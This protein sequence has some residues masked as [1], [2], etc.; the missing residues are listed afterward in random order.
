V[1][2][3]CKGR[4][5]GHPIPANIRRI[6]YFDRDTISIIQPSSSSCAWAF[7]RS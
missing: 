5:P 6:A 1:D 2:A 7:A 3:Y 4:N